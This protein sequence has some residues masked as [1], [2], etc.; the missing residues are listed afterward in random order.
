[1]KALLVVTAVFETATGV[2]PA[3]VPQAVATVLLDS[4]LDTPAGILVGRVAGVALVALGLAC[5]QSRLDEPGRGSAGMI[6]PM[7]VYNLAVAA[8]LGYG[9]TLGLAGIGLWLA[10]MAHVLLAGW[11]IACLR[12]K[13]V[14]P[15]AARNQ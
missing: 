13:P 7:L 6:G 14:S 2:A 3:L 8:L 10:V 4:P 11:C 1:M 15:P 9:W 12:P 5:W